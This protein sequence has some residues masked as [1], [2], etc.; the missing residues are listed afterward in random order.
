MGGTGLGLSIVKHI[1]N[2]YNG[3]IKVNSVV[4]EGTEFIVKFRANRKCKAKCNKM[5]RKFNKLQ[6]NVLTISQK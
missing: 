5:N 4:G 6:K 2:L 3:E 1:V